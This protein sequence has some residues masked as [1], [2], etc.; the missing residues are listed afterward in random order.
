MHEPLEDIVDLERYPLCSDAFRAQCK[1]TLDVSGALV[2]RDFMTPTAVASIQRD[3]E[4]NRHLAYYTVG[5]HNIFLAPGDARY[6]ADHPRNREVRSS[7]GCITTDQIPGDSVLHTLYEATVLREFLCAVLGEVELYPYADAL[8][9]VNL[10]YAG[11]GQELGWHF[12]N[13][14]F[15]ITLMIQG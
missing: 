8:S 10:H 15:A 13:S 7:K 6:P 9:S 4:R 3:G 12:D 14:S 2:M 1:H 5:K 11:E